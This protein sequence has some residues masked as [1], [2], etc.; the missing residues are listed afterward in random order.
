MAVFSAHGWIYT[1]PNIPRVIICISRTPMSSGKWT[2]A[3]IAFI[4]I[5][6]WMGIAQK[7]CSGLWNLGVVW[8]LD[9]DR[10]IRKSPCK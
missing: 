10:W 3:R 4:F 9:G 1:A 8:I 7:M 6:E 5:P 2:D